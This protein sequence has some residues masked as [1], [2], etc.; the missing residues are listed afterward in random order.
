MVV[1]FVGSFIFEYFFPYTL[2]PAL[3]YITMGTLSMCYECKESESDEYTNIWTLNKENHFKILKNGLK[4]LVTILLSYSRF[5]R[6]TVVTNR[7][8]CGYH[9]TT[10]ICSSGNA[11]T[12]PVYRCLQ[13]YFEV[14]AYV[15]LPSLP[16]GNISHM[17]F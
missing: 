12:T 2:F 11:Q 17:S 4:V 1:R 7:I 10:F 9:S 16:L 15:Y 14:H 13:T 8:N 6:S 3:S 5:A